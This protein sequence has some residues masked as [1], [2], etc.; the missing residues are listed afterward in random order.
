VAAPDRLGATVRVRYPDAAVGGVECGVGQV[1]GH[2][3]PPQKRLAGQ[4][5]K[6][7]KFRR[8]PTS[9]GSGAVAAGMLVRHAGEVNSDR[10]DMVDRLEHISNKYERSRRPRGRAIGVAARPNC[11]GG[12]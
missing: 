6:F 11:R 8:R 7:R 5:R 2:V 12:S 3:S 1:A 4:G 10:R 9:F